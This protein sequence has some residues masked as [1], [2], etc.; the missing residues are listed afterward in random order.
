MVKGLGST[1]LEC[2]GHETRSSHS[3]YCCGLSCISWLLG[4][5]APCRELQP[6]LTGCLKGALV[7]CNC[8]HLCLSCYTEI[9]QCARS[10]FFCVAIQDRQHLS[11]ISTCSQSTARVKNPAPRLAEKASW[12]RSPISF[13]SLQ[14]FGMDFHWPYMSHQKLLMH[15]P[16]SITARTSLSRVCVV[17]Q[18]RHVSF[19]VKK[20][21]W[22]FGNKHF[23][24]KDDINS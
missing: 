13:Q 7:R 11:C 5:H 18:H 16:W 6:T 17:P 1:G 12:Q 15:K 23:R 20:L 8:L 14:G 10:P 19:V 22:R 9:N 2:V 21:L 4:E 24:S 3:S